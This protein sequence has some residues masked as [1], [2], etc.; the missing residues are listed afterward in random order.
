M[1]DGRLGAKLSI[2]VS[3]LHL[4]KSNIGKH[5]RRYVD[6]SAASCMGERSLIVCVVAAPALA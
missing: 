3:D 1:V 5:L 2:V 4:S 6:A